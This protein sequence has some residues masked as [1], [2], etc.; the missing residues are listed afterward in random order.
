MR[1]ATLIL[2]GTFCLAACPV[3]AQD[4]ESRYAEQLDWAQ[5]RIVRRV[6]VPSIEQPQGEVQLIQRRDLLVV[7]TLLSSPILK[8][9]V[10]AIDAKEGRSW[11]EAREGHVESRHYREELFRATEKSWDVFRQRGDRNQ[12]RQALMIEFILGP[13]QAL[14]ALSLPQ[15][16]GAHGNLRLLGKQPIQVWRGAKDY[17]RENI[18]EIVRDSFQLDAGAAEELLKP[19]WPGLNAATR[20]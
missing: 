9:V 10:A 1:V 6:V 12:D 5:D 4:S 8:R 18:F 3:V 11:P 15:L 16:T 19:L 14:I 2:I 7:Q 20:D 13:R 17:V